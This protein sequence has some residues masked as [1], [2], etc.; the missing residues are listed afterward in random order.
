[1]AGLLLALSLVACGDEATP[2][3]ATQAKTLPTIP[4]NQ[5][6]TIK[7]ASYN[8][9]TPGLGG[10]GTQQLIDEFQ[11]KFPNIKIDARNV[12]SADILKSIVAD[13]AAGDPPDVA[14]LVLNNLDYV[15]NNLPVQALDQIVPKDEY[16]AYTKHIVPQA[17][18]LGVYNGHLYGSPYTFST[19]TLFYNADIFKAAGLDP[20]KPPTTWDEVRKYA[21]QIKDKTGKPAIVIDALPDPADW[22]IQSIV[23]SNG[24]TTI[25]AD[26][27][28]ATFN[29]P[30]AVE[31]FKMW[32]DLVK[33]GLHP[34]FT[35]A[36]AT[37]A[38]Q[39]GNLAMMLYTTVLLPAF[40][41]A[42][43]GK[44]DL[45]TAA[46]PAF[47]T[48]PVHPVNSG[49]A[50]FMMSKDPLKQRAAFEF[51]KFVSSQ[52]GY[53][54]IT[55]TIGYLPLRDDVVDDPN[56]LK[57]VLDKDPRMLP[58][59]KQL[60]NLETWVSWPGKDSVQALKIFT[61]AVYDV[62]YDGQDVQKTMDTAAAR[63]N[64]LISK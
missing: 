16:D 4:A 53:T 5:T 7:F 11:A 62:V 22:I 13:A 6:V 25:S 28:K 8:Y 33:D 47:G 43:K 42:A 36:D 41:E 59:I 32:Q 58:T 29:E 21:Q 1:V 50:L 64:E 27:K 12:G 20:N 2:T 14:Q 57:P 18:K 51:L 60:A 9:G 19:P 37:A 63:V 38:M 23:N 15:A 34:K 48:K 10:K 44:F 30:A 49:S 31:A 39:N 40:S 17:L 46:E 54:I 45:R 35:S 61:Q 55:G 3:A 52:R 26:H 56:Y 24:G